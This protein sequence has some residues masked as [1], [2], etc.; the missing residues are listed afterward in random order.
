MKYIEK[1]EGTLDRVIR[2]V[3]GLSGIV[4]GYI[5][6]PWFYLL[7]V[8]GL[9]TAVTGFCWLYKLFGKK[10]C[11]IRNIGTKGDI[12]KKSSLDV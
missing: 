4:L 2:L 7:A 10:T 3:L 9:L 5:V 1:N 8:A 11:S 12:T 6:S